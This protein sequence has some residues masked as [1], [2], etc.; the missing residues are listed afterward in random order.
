MSTSRST[1]DKI[2]CSFCILKRKCKTFGHRPQAVV[3]H[4]YA[5][6]FPWLGEQTFIVYKPDT[7]HRP[8]FGHHGNNA[9]NPP[10]VVALFAVGVSLCNNEHVCFCYVVLPKL[11]WLRLLCAVK[12]LTIYPSFNLSMYALTN[13]VDNNNVGVFSTKKQFPLKLQSSLEMAKHFACD[14]GR[15]QSGTTK[16]KQGPTLGVCLISLS[17]SHHCSIIQSLCPL[18]MNSLLT[19]SHN[20]TYNLLTVLVN[21]YKYPVSFYPLNTCVEKSSFQHFLSSITV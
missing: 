19:N 5:L 21:P 6:A 14:L 20:M 9:G 18:L 15:C 16:G 3:G 12:F 1:N 13:L 17:G 7:F 10:Q 8:D 2:P 4:N 11:S